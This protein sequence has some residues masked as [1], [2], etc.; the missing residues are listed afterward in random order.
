MAI[1][2]PQLSIDIDSIGEKESAVITEALLLTHDDEE[3]ATQ[4]LINLALETSQRKVASKKSGSSP[5]IQHLTGEQRLTA[6]LINGDDSF[7][8]EDLDSLA[9]MEA[10]DII[11]GPLMKGMSEVGVLFQEGNLFLTQVVRSARVMKRAV[12]L[13]QPRLQTKG[14]EEH[15]TIGTIVFATVKGD[16]HDI[17]KNIVSLVLTC[18][19]F[20]VIDLG[21]MVPPETIVEAAQTY[22]ADLVALSGLITPSLSQMAHL[23]SLFHSNKINIPILIGGATTSEKHTALKLEPLYPRSTFYGKDATQTVSIA[24]KLLSNQREAYIEEVDKRNQ[25]IRLQS[26]VQKKEIISLSEAHLRRHIKR[27]PTAV[28]EAPT[29]E[30]VE[31]ISLEDLISLINWDMFVKGWDVPRNCPEAQK[32][33][34]EAKELLSTKRVR[35]MFSEGIKGVY[36]LFPARKNK[37]GGIEIL[38]GENR[39][40]ETLYFL[41]SQI[42]N[43]KGVC[44]SLGDYIHDSQIDTIGMFVASSALTLS[45]LLKEYERENDIYSS[46]LLSTLSDSLAEAFSEYLHQHIVNPLFLSSTSHNSIR[47]AIGY[48]SVPNH[49]MKKEIF[50]ALQARE[51]IGVTLTEQMAMDPVSSVCGLYVADEGISYFALPSISKEQFE[52]YATLIGEKSEKLFHY[53]PIDIVGE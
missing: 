26:K 2:N 31:N 28:I 22:H 44:Y 33:E 3:K 4:E 9:S 52:T 37:K 6:A 40:I 25:E 14:T 23:C 15:K 19:N 16:V 13:L 24:L 46:M 21:V 50:K 51:H 38:D 11:E 1:V 49:L 34:K 41:R 42:P 7:L 32:L 29:I 12:E 20:K 35:E 18:N 47:P 17:G 43:S 48:P 53:M 8:Q 27:E 5:S 45:S 36:G 39:V 10:V 30:V